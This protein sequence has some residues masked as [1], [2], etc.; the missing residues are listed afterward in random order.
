V[1]DKH[2]RPGRSTSGRE[3]ER[4]RIEVDRADRQ[5]IER[6]AASLRTGAIRAGY[7]GMEHKHLAFG[8]ALVLDE[9]ARHV[10]ELHPDVRA[11]AMR[12]ARMMVGE[13]M[14]S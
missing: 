1:I 4:R 2:W 13:T 10:R 11:Q 7:T 3:Q 5:L 9:L 14:P 12:G 6:A 8:L